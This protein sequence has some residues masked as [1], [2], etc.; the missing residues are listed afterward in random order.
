MVMKLKYTSIFFP[1]TAS[2][3]PYIKVE[4]IKSSALRG[5]Y[6]LIVSIY[7]YSFLIIV[8]LYGWSPQTIKPNAYLGNISNYLRGTIT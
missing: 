1:I 5:D 4:C 8:N 7:S 2:L 3:P 6:S